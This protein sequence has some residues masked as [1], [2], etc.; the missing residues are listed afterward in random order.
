MARYVALDL[1][2]DPA[3]TWILVFALG[4]LAGL[5]VSLFTPR[6]RV[7]VRVWSEEPPDGAA[8]GA[9]TVVTVAGLARGDDV[10]LQGEV[11]R[12]L[13]ALPGVDDVPDAPAP[14]ATEA[15]TAPAPPRS[16]GPDSTDR[17]TTKG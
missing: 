16:T 5:A 8:S 11:D 15:R 14:R 7:W 3:L 10:G 9:K 2:H 1:R 13:A 17:P 4:A 6:R 12:V